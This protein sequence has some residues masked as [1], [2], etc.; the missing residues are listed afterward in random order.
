[1]TSTIAVAESLANLVIGLAAVGPAPLSAIEVAT[2][3]VDLALQRFE[4]GDRSAP[5]ARDAFLAG[6]LV[7]H[8]LRRFPATGRD[9]LAR[10]A[11]LD[12]TIERTLDLMAPMVGASERTLAA[13]VLAGPGW[14]AV[15]PCRALA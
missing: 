14:L 4:R 3:A 13:R 6:V 9:Q 15:E 11:R 1:M 7:A 10:M 2:D 5:L 8:L 12:R